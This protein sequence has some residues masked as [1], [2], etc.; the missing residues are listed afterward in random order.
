MNKYPKKVKQTN[1]QKDKEL[2]CIYMLDKKEDL[3]WTAQYVEIEVS[4]SRVT[5]HAISRT[6]VTEKKKKKK[7]REAKDFLRVKHIFAFST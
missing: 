3:A 1:I 4:F 7:W 5:T 6:A 2:S